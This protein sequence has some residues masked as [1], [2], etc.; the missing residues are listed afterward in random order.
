MPSAAATGFSRIAIAAF[1]VALGAML[2]VAGAG[3]AYQQKLVVLGS[4]FTTIRWGVWVGLGAA[5]LGLIGAWVTR[6][7]AQLRGFPLALAAVVI[8][9]ATFVVPYLHYQGSRGA[10]P[11]HDITTDTANPPAFVAV[12]PLRRGAPNPVEYGGP[13]IAQ[14]QGIAY[15]DIVPLQLSGPPEKAFERALAAARELGWEI[16]AAVPAEG[17]IEATDSTRWFGLKDDIVVRVSANA[18][19]SRIDVRS[20]SRL[21]RGDQG[22]NARRIREYL[23]RVRG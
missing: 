23:K 22:M 2:A 10:P 4:A 20:V 12:V 5:A 1:A 6:P 3:P 19:A 16:V 14:Q 15:P 18:G 11:I 17:R 13:S 21:G 7:G 9:A 8:G